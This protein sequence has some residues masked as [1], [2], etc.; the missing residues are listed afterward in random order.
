VSRQ[1]AHELQSARRT[2]CAGWRNNSLP[3]MDHDNGNGSHSKAAW[4]PRLPRF[5]ARCTI[6]RE[7]P[8]LGFA[9]QTRFIDGLSRHLAARR[10]VAGGRRLPARQAREPLM[11]G[12]LAQIVPGAPRAASRTACPSPRC[13]QQMD[14]IVADAVRC[15]TAPPASRGSQSR[16]HSRSTWGKAAG[17]HSTSGLGCAQRPRFALL[18]R[19][20]AGSTDHHRGTRRCGDVSDWGTVH[21]PARFSHRP[22]QLPSARRLLRRRL[23]R[24]GA[25]SRCRSVETSASEPAVQRRRWKRKHGRSRER[26]GT[27]QAGRAPEMRF[28]LGGRPSFLV[29]ARRP[30]PRAAP[31]STIFGRCSAGQAVRAGVLLGP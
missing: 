18:R 1:S 4:S 5:A 3:H 24:G 29:R 10:A 21:R 11:C 16:A 12:W 19:A 31:L 20:G 26:C 28:N 7:L 15:G 2:G 30:S 17:V 23:R 8:T 27:R 6:A 9:R 25:P 13:Q 14:P 22:Q